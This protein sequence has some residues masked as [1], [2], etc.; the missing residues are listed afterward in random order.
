MDITCTKCG[1]SNQSTA[2]FCARCGQTLRP[3]VAPSQQEEG[4]LDL[5]WLQSVQDQA[6]KLPT[7]KLRDDQVDQAASIPSDLPPTMIALLP[8]CRWK[9]SLKPRTPPTLTPPAPP[10]R[11]KVRPTSRLQAGWSASSNQPRLSLPATS[12][13]TSLKSLPMSCPGHT[14][15]PHQK[16]P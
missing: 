16:T 13:T 11:P 6:E 1:V 12:R 15:L 4:G 3:N 10:K 7:D 14:A 9:P 8:P 5:P 2:R